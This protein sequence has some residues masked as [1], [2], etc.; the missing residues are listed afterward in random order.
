LLELKCGGLLFDRHEPPFSRR[1]VVYFRTAL[2]TDGKDLRQLTTT[3]GNDAHAVWS[4]DAGICFS[5]VIIA[6]FLR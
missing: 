4:P 1:F 2:Y 6:C 3:P 5:A